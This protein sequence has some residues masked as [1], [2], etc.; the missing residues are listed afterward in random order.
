M[1]EKNI[2]R[3]KDYWNTFYSQFNYSIP[4]QFC[5][6]MASEISTKTKIIEYGCGNGRDSIFLAKNGYNIYALDLS[7]EA[8]NKNIEKSKEIKNNICDH[9]KLKNFNLSNYRTSE[10][11]KSSSFTALPLLSLTPRFSFTNFT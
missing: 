1:N 5:A 8:I 4:S 11:F 6:L 2:G 7:E 3:E 10:R 9:S